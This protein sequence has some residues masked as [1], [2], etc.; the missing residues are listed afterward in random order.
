V[1]V[2]DLQSGVEYLIARG[3]ADPKRV[4]IWGSSYGGLL[5]TMSLF[6]KPGVYAAGV[7]SAPATNAANHGVR[8]HDH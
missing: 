2:E 1:D 8:V 6:T 3:V 5:T 7:A 4:G